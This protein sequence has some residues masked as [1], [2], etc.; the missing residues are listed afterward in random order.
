MA[1]MHFESFMPA[2]CCMAPEMPTA[3]YKSG[4]TTLPV[5]PTCTSQM[6]S[7]AVQASIQQASS[8]A[9]M[10]RE[11]KPNKIRLA[12]FSQQDT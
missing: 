5:W 2:R 3:I 4:A 11:I 9:G 8:L 10:P 12:G 6:Q 7:N 1:T